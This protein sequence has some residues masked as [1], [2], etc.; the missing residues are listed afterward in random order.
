MRPTDVQVSLLTGGIDKPYAFG[1]ATAL[2][3]NGVRLDF[4]G[5]KAVDS[6][7]LHAHPNVTVLNLR[8]DQNENV[9]AI[10][11]ARRITAYYARLLRYAA[12]AQPRLFHILWNNRFQTVDRTL[13]MAYYKLRR[14]KLALTAHNV[15]GAKRDATDSFVNRAT[16]RIQYRLADHIFVHT[17][18]MKAELVKDFGVSERNVTVIPFGINNSVPNTTVMTSEEAKRRLGIQ[19]GEK[20]ILFFGRIGPYKG[21]EYLVAALGE[22]L[23]KD[24]TYR[25]IIAGKAKAGSEAYCDDIRRRIGVEIERG[26]VVEHIG[27]VP[28]EQTEL[29]FK[30]ADLLVLPYT[31]IFQSGVL[32][33]GYSFGLPVV[34][35][36]V[37]SM[38]DDVVEGRTGL[39]CR[40]RDSIDLANT[41]EA[42]FKSDMFATLSSLR[43]EIRDFVNERHS[44][45]VVS[46][47]TV[48]IYTSLL[49]NSR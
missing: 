47:R 21:L 27:F 31:D 3:S 17:E 37:G 48:N 44:W 45:S 1:L 4:I 2:A 14:K 22:L 39:L 36:D 6:P 34:A 35:S 25:L 43:H 49:S 28:D 10:A 29:Y 19:D 16:L 41:I 12:V 9:S 11:K 18:R 46:Q 33:L 24:K 40:P 5:S 23:Q 7:E 20:T 38:R 30:A 8:D 26:R 32:F 15:N 13:L 42:Y